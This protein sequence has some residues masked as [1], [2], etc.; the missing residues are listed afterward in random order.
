M[1]FP[2]VGRGVTNESS[3]CHAPTCEPQAHTKFSSYRREKEEICNLP[4]SRS[5]CEGWSSVICPL[6]TASVMLTFTALDSNGV[7]LSGGGKTLIVYPDGN[8]VDK[9]A[10]TLIPIPEESPRD[11]VISW[12][13]EYNEGG[14]TIRG[15][16]HDEGKQVSFV[17]E[18]DNVRIAFLSSPLQDWTDHQIEMVGDIDVLTMPSDDAK[19]IQTLLDGFDPR[20]IILTPGKDHAAA[21]KIVDPKE[22]V[23]EWKLKGA[24]PAE[25]RE[26]M[27]FAS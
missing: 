13:G 23:S 18:A 25:G 9:S 4:A 21:L 15:I 10:L 14:I 22:T 7:R 27:V 3:I 8:G 11:G 26:A 2:M 1:A 6:Y 12:P 20:V 19:I 17:V 24:L 16:G 5:R